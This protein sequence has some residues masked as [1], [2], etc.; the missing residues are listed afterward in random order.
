MKL[1]LD[2]GLIKTQAIVLTIQNESEFS[3]WCAAATLAA[4]SGNSLV[5]VITAPIYMKT[6]RDYSIGTA[7]DPIPYFRLTCVG[8]GRFEWPGLVVATSIGRI[9]PYAVRGRFDNCEFTKFECKGACIELLYS[10]MTELVLKDPYYHNCSQVVGTNQ[11]QTSALLKGSVAGLNLEIDGLLSVDNGQNNFGHHYDVDVTAANSKV[12]QSM[13]VNSGPLDIQGP[14][15][16]S[17]STWLHD[18]PGTTQWWEWTTFASGVNREYARCLLIKDG[19]DAYNVHHNSSTGQYLYAYEGDWTELIGASWLSNTYSLAMPDIT[20]FAKQTG[21]STW[22]DKTGWQGLGLDAT[23]GSSFALTVIGAGED[24][25]DEEYTVT[26]LSEWVAAVAACVAGAGKRILIDVTQ[27]IILA[28]N[29]DYILGNVNNLPE[30]V[31]VECSGTGSIS[32]ENH[33]LASGNLNVVVLVAL[34]SRITNVVFFGGSCGGSPWKCNNGPN[35][36]EVTFTNCSFT[37]CQNDKAYY[38]DPADR[39]SRLYYCASVIGGG[40]DFGTVTITGC[41][42]LRTC[43]SSTAWTHSIYINSFRHNVINNSFIDSG[44]HIALQKHA[45]PGNRMVLTG[46]TFTNNAGKCVWNPKANPAPD[47]GEFEY[48]FAAIGCAVYTDEA[49]EWH[50]TGNTVNGEWR[51]VYNGYWEHIYPTNF[52]WDLN[53]YNCDLMNTAQFG[54]RTTPPSPPL[55]RFFSETTWKDPTQ[56]PGG[57]GNGWDVNSTFNLTTISGE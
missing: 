46:N 8:N 9:L 48:P 34:R 19:A 1:G 45:T 39:D 17:Y 33:T 18:K 21:V 24:P 27:P 4:E 30:L 29:V 38:E 40:T 49:G 16:V 14:C 10:G 53:I 3:D 26:N 37:D 44:S 11:T 43:R 51:H 28:A 55:P 56:H 7:L 52:Y 23:F 20:K 13:F 54:R 6:D 36:L 31:S 2:L 5:G 42:F 41:T 15:E 35:V 25:Y 22:Y 57:D 47:L 12:T 50:V 32:A